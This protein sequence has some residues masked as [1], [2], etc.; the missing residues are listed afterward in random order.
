MSED[1]FE[2]ESYLDPVQPQEEDSPGEPYLEDEG[3]DEGDEEYEP[4]IVEIFPEEEP[5]PQVQPSLDVTWAVLDT[6]PGLDY[7]IKEA[8]D[9]LDKMQKDLGIYPYQTKGG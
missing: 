9:S 8:G 4:N 2:E 7:L 1:D 3:D 6:E 5:E